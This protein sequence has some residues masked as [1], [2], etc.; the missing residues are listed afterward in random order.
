MKI[1][2]VQGTH[3]TGKTTTCA[4]II[5][6]LVK[7]GY[8]VG[9]IKSIHADNFTLETEGSNTHTHKMAGAD[10]VTALGLYETDVMFRGRLDMDTL[11]GA[12]DCQ[13][14]V[15]E[16]HSDGTVVCPNISVGITTDDLDGQMD[17]NTIAFSG[18]ISGDYAKSSGK[19]YH[20]IPVINAL[21]D[22]V[23]LVDLIEEKTMHFI[24]RRTCWNRMW[25]EISD[26]QTKATK[27]E[28]WNNAAATYRKKPK[29][30]E[31][32]EYV[33]QFYKYMALK[34]G[35][36]VFDMGCGSGVLAIPIAERGNEVYAADFS[37]EMLRHLMSDAEEAGVA[38]RIHPIML[39]WNE[40]WSLRDLPRCDVAIASRSLI[41]R[42]LSSS[43]DKLESV[44]KDRVCLGA[45]EKP[46]Q[47]D[48]G[49]PGYS[50]YMIIMGDL[51]ERGKYPEL[52]YIRYGENSR[53]AFISWELNLCCRNNI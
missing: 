9:S 22:V 17:D 6:E 28:R 8:T 49:G 32:D 21:T 10:P 11:L 19:Y 31:R 18:I 24:P 53:I 33:E 3:H 43:L 36:T 5:K 51:M 23:E 35:E 30:G 26:A 1:I 13:W 34:P 47:S 39:D 4:E 52:K 48:G 50:C 14:M 15:I 37:E 25:T 20:D 38:D 44:A 16:G 2:N 29:E 45:W 27:V 41:F 42:D 7:R 46:P 40:N 12:Y